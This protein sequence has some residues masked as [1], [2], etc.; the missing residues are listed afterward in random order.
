[1]QEDLEVICYI[2]THRDGRAYV[3]ITS[4]TVAQRKS[5]HKNDAKTNPRTPFHRAIHDDG[6]DAFTWREL[7][8]GDEVPMRALEALLIYEWELNIEAKGFNKHGGHEGQIRYQMRK[9]DWNEYGPPWVNVPLM[10]WGEPVELLDLLNDVSAAVKWL[11]DN[12]PSLARISHRRGG[13]RLLPM[14]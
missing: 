14:A 1:M 7:A 4:G 9:P 3:G 12:T 2:A 10:D 6:V 5:R 13:R 11:E 8:R